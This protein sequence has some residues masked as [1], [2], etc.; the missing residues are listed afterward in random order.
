MLLARNKQALIQETPLEK[1]A[2]YQHAILIA[3]PIIAQ[4]LINAA[5]SSADV[6]MLG[7]VSQEALSAS[8]LANQVQFVLMIIFFGLSSGVT[9]LTAQYW[10]KGD[11]VTIEKILGI[12]VRFSLSVGLVFA[13]AAFFA[14]Q[15]LMRI[16]TNDPALIAEGAVYLRILSVSYLFTSFSSI[17]LNLMRSIERVFIS[18]SVYAISLSLNI[19]INAIFIFGLFGAPKLGLVGVAIGTVTARLVELLICVGDLLHS[20]T[21]K[22]HLRYVFASNPVLMKDFLRISLP[23]TL[24]DT[25]WSVAFSMYSVILGHLGSDAVAANSVA[26]VARNLGTVICFGMASATGIVVGKTIGENRLTHARVYADRMVFL[27]SLSGI[28]GGI[29]I[30]FSR[31]IFLMMGHE[32]TPHATAYLQV[33]L[34]ITCYYVWG[35]G[36]NT[37]WIGGCFRAGGD[38]K[39]GMICDTIDMWCFSVPMGFFCA[40]VLKLPVMGVYFILCLDEFVKMPFIIHHYRSYRWIQNITRDFDNPQEGEKQP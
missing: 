9:A 20:K 34:L 6:I 14:P 27:T 4:N 28:L 11:T 26:S 29:L 35:Q 38:A 5:V 32:L 40:F 23:S 8:S 10:G 17:Y 22:F 36:V 2:F 13:A 24:N 7:Y 25:S 15:L 18:T 1:R 21:I 3:L 30:F 37:A 39:Y 31:P 19:C 33:M 12:A 16:F